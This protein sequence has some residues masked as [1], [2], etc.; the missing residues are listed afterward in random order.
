MMLTMDPWSTAE[1]DSL[2][3]IKVIKTCHFKLPPLPV[4]DIKSINLLAYR[5]RNEDYEMALLF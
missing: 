1:P 3:Q 2:I 5:P 4:Q